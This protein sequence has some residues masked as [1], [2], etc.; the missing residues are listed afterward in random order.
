MDLV[1]TTKEGNYYHIYDF[2]LGSFF[3]E[4]YWQLQIQ[5]QKAVY[6]KGINVVN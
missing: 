5:R 2:I 6:F 1:Q 3:D 4:L